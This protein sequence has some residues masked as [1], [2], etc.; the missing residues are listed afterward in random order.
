MV[1]NQLEYGMNVVGK[2]L[3]YIERGDFEGLVEKIKNKITKRWV[4][5]EYDPEVILKHTADILAE[6]Y[7]FVKRREF[8]ARIYDYLGDREH[9]SNIRQKAEE[10]SHSLCMALEMNRRDFFSFI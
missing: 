1:K 5:M 7:F 3:K 8:A 6:S 9:A 10:Y 4:R 2:S